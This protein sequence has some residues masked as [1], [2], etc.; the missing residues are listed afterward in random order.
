MA[1]FKRKDAKL[2]GHKAEDKRKDAKLQGHKAEDK[3]KDAKLQ[4]HKTEDKRKDA[5]TQ[6]RKEREVQRAPFL[7][8]MPLE[9]GGFFKKAGY[10]LIFWNMFAF[11]KNP[12]FA[13]GVNFVHK[14]AIRPDSLCA[15]ASLRLCVEP[16]HSLNMKSAPL[17]TRSA[18]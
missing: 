17:N 14:R 2:Q 13:Q 7:R 8:S 11:L 15:F 6:R 9:K 5:K 1:K 12:P 4:G 10:E 18:L 16:L 3:R